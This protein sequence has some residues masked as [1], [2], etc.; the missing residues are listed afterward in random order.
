MPNSRECVWWKYSYDDPKTSKH[1]DFEWQARICNRYA[2]QGCPF[3][4]GNIVWSGFNDL[5]SRNQELSFEW[6]YEKNRGLKPEMVTSKSNKKVWWNCASCGKNMALRDFKK[7]RRA[8]V[9]VLWKED[10]R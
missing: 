4:S 10:G 6:D 1:H 7:S 5:V 2:S 3:L 8:T 9:Y